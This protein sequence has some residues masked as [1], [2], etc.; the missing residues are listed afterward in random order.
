M[1]ILHYNLKQAL[2]LLRADQRWSICFSK[3]RDKNK[4]AEGQNGIKKQTSDCAST[5]RINLMI[6][7]KEKQA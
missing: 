1:N 5:W 2:T 7:K 4:I 3:N 6:Q